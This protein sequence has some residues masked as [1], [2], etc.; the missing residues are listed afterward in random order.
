MVPRELSE[1]AVEKAFYCGGKLLIDVAKANEKFGDGDEDVIEYDK[2]VSLDQE[3][4]GLVFVAATAKENDEQ[5]VKEYFDFCV[6]TEILQSFMDATPDGILSR[7]FCDVRFLASLSHPRIR[8]YEHPLQEWLLMHY[9]VRSYDRHQRYL[10]LDLDTYTNSLLKVEVSE[11]DRHLAQV[12][13]LHDAKIAFLRR[14]I[15]ECAI[16][17]VYRDDENIAFMRRGR[18]PYMDKTHGNNT[19]TVLWNEVMEELESYYTEEQ[20]EKS[21]EWWLGCNIPPPPEEEDIVE[22]RLPVAAL[23]Q[24]CAGARSR[25]AHQ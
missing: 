18:V 23:A 5:D 22:A 1:E 7:R 9:R 25:L 2:F 24:P 6:K 17:A 15:E 12:T 16:Q 11:Q 19:G 3:L 21:K 20:A 4:T 14:D 8:H 10:D 13:G